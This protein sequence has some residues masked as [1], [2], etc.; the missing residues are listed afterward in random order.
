MTQWGDNRNTTRPQAYRTEPPTW[1]LIALM[2]M[3]GATMALLIAA[4]V[5][6]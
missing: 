4:E 2:L 3:C 6:R 1:T 5:L